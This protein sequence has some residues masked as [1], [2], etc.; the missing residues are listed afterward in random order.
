[1][2]AAAAAPV[3]AMAAV[4]PVAGVA[5]VD[6][7]VGIAPAPSPV[8]PAPPPADAPAPAAAALR[9]A[10]DG[11]GLA[12]A[13]FSGVVAHLRPASIVEGA[14]AGEVLDHGLV[15]AGAAQLDQVVGGQRVE[16]ALPRPG[17]RDDR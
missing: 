17:V 12:F 8:G 5:P 2:A 15:H 11:D 14:D 6:G 10:F 3:A 16:P 9:R 1:M 13:A 4:A 7:S